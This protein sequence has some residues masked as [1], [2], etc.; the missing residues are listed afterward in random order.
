MEVHKYLVMCLALLCG[1]AAF[2]ATSTYTATGTSSG[3]QTENALATF[4]TGNGTVGVTLNDLISNPRNIGQN[5]SGLFFTLSNGATIG[6]MTSSGIELR[7][8]SSGTYSI[9]SPVS[10]GWVLTS[11]GGSLLLEVLN[12][13]EA[14]KHT[15][16]GPS[17]NGSYSGGAYSKANASIAGNHTHNPFLESGVTFSLTI[18]GVTATTTVTNATFLFGTAT[19]NRLAAITPVPEADVT[20]L[21]LLGASLAGLSCGIGRFRKAKQSRS[22]PGN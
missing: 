10:T 9:G 13:P 18:S 3:G 17:S 7:V 8:N 5:I 15:I 11:S 16:I 4:V 22:K 21:V 12:T 1:R 20:M 2:A 6:S 14:P 19:G